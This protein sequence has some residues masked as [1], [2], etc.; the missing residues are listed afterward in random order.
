MAEKELGKSQNDK[1]ASPSSTITQH[2]STSGSAG[3]SS[4]TSD[5]STRKLMDVK[6]ELP[7]LKDVNEAA[8][9]AGKKALSWGQLLWE[10]WYW[11]I[12]LAVALA[13]SR[14]TSGS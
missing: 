4:T 14:M 1:P 9:G 7:A 13:V 10:K 2:T 3:S 5:E 11:G 8:A 12:F 6:K